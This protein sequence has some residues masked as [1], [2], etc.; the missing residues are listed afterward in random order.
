MSLVDPHT[1]IEQRIK[2]NSVKYLH[3]ILVKL[4]VIEAA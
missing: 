4:Q 1:D 3:P 2:I